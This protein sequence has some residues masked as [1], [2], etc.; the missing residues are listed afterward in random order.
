MVTLTPLKTWLSSKRRRRPRLRP[1]VRGCDRHDSLREKKNKE[2]LFSLSA[3]SR[4]VTAPVPAFRAW[5]GEGRGRG[6]ATGFS[7]GAGAAADPLEGAGTLSRLL[8]LWA[9]PLVQEGYSR[10]LMPEDLW[11]IRPQV[12]AESC[13]RGFSA[14]WKAAGDKASV[15]RALGDHWPQLGTALLLQFG[16]T[17]TI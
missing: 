2:A 16:F 14:R 5:R 4:A 3:V 13:H 17:V 1:E 12:S 11:P 7:P 6:W 15:L 10:V 9:T 8:L